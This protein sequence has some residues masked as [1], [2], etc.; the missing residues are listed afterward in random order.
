MTEPIEG[1]IVRTGRDAGYEPPPPVIHVTVRIPHGADVSVV[2]AEPGRPWWRPAY[3]L[4]TAILTAAGLVPLP[5][6]GAPAAHWALTLG[7]V[8]AEQS[9]GGAWVIA[10]AAVGGAL[11]NDRRVRNRPGRWDDEEHAWRPGW[12]ARALLCAAISGAAL[13]LPLFDGLVYVLTGVNP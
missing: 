8:A 6:I 3:T 4:R 12:L 5:S 1:R 13:A 2:E 7:D 10:A 9:M 11:A